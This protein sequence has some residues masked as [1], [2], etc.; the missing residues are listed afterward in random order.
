MPMPHQTAM[1]APA[2]TT[3]PTQHQTATSMAPTAM[4]NGHVSANANANWPH[5]VVLTFLK[6]C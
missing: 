4:P 5:I 1:S 2:Q 6:A 3:M